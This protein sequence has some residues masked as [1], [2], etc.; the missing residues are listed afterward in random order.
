MEQQ[1]N[2]IRSWDYLAWG[3]VL[4]LWAMLCVYCS[5]EEWQISRRFRHS[6]TAVGIVTSAQ[7]GW[8]SRDDGESPYIEYRF[9]T[10]NGIEYTGASSHEFFPEG[11]TAEVEYLPSDPYFN[12]IKGTNA[13]RANIVQYLFFAGLMFFF[14]GWLFLLG[15]SDKTARYVGDKEIAPNNSTFARFPQIILS[16]V[17]AYLLY[18]AA[19][20]V[21]PYAFYQILR[22]IVCCT[23]ILFAVDAHRW[24]KTWALWTFAVMAILFNPIVPIHLTRDSWSVIDRIAAVVILVG[25]FTVKPIRDDPADSGAIMS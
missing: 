14:A 7:P 2:T 24:K 17:S 25:A 20:E 5:I 4:T 21:Y 1:P 16:A 15:Y 19:F 13:T 18:D 3:V 8:K 23:A 12:R 22:W 9:K 10:S 11:E 6:S